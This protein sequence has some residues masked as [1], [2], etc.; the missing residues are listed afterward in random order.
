MLATYAKA[1]VA[2][3][4][5]KGKKI[6]KLAGREVRYN[7]EKYLRMVVDSL[8]FQSLSDIEIILVDDGSTDGSLDIMREYERLDR[9]VR[10]IQN[11]EKSDGAA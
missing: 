7:S 6:L 11:T 9:R 8:L 5:Y 3:E 2:N 10:V 1:L 4:K